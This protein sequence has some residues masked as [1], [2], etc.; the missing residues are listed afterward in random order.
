MFIQDCVIRNFVFR[1]CVQDPIKSML[2]SNLAKI[3]AKIFSDAAGFPG[4]NIT[5]IRGITSLFSLPT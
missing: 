4:F 3:Q 5:S 1:D 2:Q